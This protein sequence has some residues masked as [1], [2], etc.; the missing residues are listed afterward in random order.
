MITGDNPKGYGQELYLFGKKKGSGESIWELKKQ[1]GI[2]STAMTDLFK[3]NQTVEQMILSGFF[4]SI[5]LYIEPTTLQKQI[6]A[7]WLQ[8]V[9][10]SHLKNKPF[11]K[12]SIGQQRVVLIVRALH[13]QPPIVNLDEPLE[14]L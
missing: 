6:A 7:Q 8:V 14:S 2:F 1:I 3:R 10:M 12:L 9:A 11:N 5:G 13:K 4:D